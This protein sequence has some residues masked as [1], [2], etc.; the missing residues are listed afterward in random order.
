MFLLGLYRIL[1]S[2]AMRHSQCSLCTCPISCCFCFFSVHSILKTAYNLCIFFNFLR[3]WTFL[4]RSI[5]SLFSW[6]HTVFHVSKTSFFW[7]YLFFIFTTFKKLIYFL[8][9]KFIFFELMWRSY[10]SS[11]ILLILLIM[12]LYLFIDTIR[13]FHFLFTNKINI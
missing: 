10:W 4:L 9:I 11:R 6:L 7:I 12:F 13:V 3:S 8:L 1:K 5:F 2:C